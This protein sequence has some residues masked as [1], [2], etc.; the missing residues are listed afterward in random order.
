MVK[1]LENGVQRWR[2]KPAEIEA[3]R[4]TG[5][6][7]IEIQDWTRELEPD[8]I[9]CCF[10]PVDEEDRAEDPEIIAEVWDKLHSTWV[11][12]KAGQW[13]IHGIQGE[14]YPCDA[15]VFEQSYEKVF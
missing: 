12:V 1:G 13:V 7:W 3:I 4:F 11:G 2:K 8:L 10:F 9:R 15:G 14:F 6:N 5:D